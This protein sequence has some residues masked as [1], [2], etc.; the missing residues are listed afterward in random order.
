MSVVHLARLEERCENIDTVI[1]TV[2]GALMSESTAVSDSCLQVLNADFWMLTERIDLIGDVGIWLNAWLG[3]LLRS[4]RPFSW[5]DTIYNNRLFTTAPLIPLMDGCIH[6]PFPPL[7]PSL[8]IPRPVFPPLRPSHPPSSLPYLP[9]SLFKGGP[10]VQP[11]ENF[12][13]SYMY[14]RE[15]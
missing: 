12:L 8:S 14:V 5:V 1:F 15:S 3:Y 10:E 7:P 9:R 11:P 2:A 4:S 6:P 13:K